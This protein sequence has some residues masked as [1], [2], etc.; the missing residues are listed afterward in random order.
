[1]SEPAPVTSEPSQLAL[2]NTL[3]RDL[4]DVY[5]AHGVCAAAANSLASH[6]QVRTLTA[7][8]E[9]TSSHYDVWICSSEGQISQDRW[10]D[11]DPFLERIAEGDRAAHYEKYLA[12]AGEHVK[13]QLWR[14]IDNA[15]LAV[16]IP[17]PSRTDLQ[18]PS[19][20]ICLLDPGP[21]CP[22]TS[23]GLDSTSDVVGLFLE[24]AFLRQKT[25]Q[26]SVEFGI[27]SDI[28]HSLTS[29]LN[30]EEIIAQVTYAVRRVLGAESLTIGLTDSTG[31]KVVFVEALMGPG[32]RDVPSVSFKIGQGIAGWVALHGEPAIVN[33]AYADRRFSSR[34]DRDTGFLTNS[35]LCVPLKVEQRVIGVLEAINKQNGEFDEND[36][37][38]LQAISGP[39]AVA[40]E[41]ALL[42]SDVLAEKRRI[43][44]IFARM[45]EGLLTARV[46]GRV[47]AAN[48]ALLELLGLDI[49]KAVGQQAGD[50]VVT[51]PTEFGEFLRSV[52]SADGEAPQLAGDLR[53]ADGQ[54]VPVLVSGSKIDRG[55]GET[56]EL[57]FVFSDL[58]QVR[59]V[60]RMRDDFFH[61]IVH[62]LRTPLAT[63][64]M[65]ARL[66]RDGRIS[67]DELKSH[68]FLGII[69]RESDRLQK[70]VRQM[71]LLAKLEANHDVVKEESCYLNDV[72]EQLLPPL[73]DRA[74]VK[75]LEFRQDIQP[76]L[77]TVQGGEELL[78]MVF[79][80]L[81]ENGINF[82]SDGSVTIRARSAGDVVRVEVTDE[83]IGIPAEA[84]PNLFQRFY[85]AQSAVERGIAGTGLGLYM[86]KEGLE[87]CGG[88]ID[89]ESKENQGSKFIVKVPIVVS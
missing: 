45:S 58:R 52:R 17:A 54:F 79:K 14:L 20:T 87:T 46:D 62:E 39:L 16:Q 34:V 22:L 30:L 57:I 12:P 10:S 67:G 42:H 73:S 74:M 5:D 77:P 48:N 19:A 41:N 83:G 23:E 55:S 36:S 35:V 11:E 88:T 71:L 59:E 78:Y 81:V 51:R 61:N 86:V 64:L 44:T 13:S 31:D 89:V 26:Q 15:T 43:E 38:L 65:Y 1:M 47:S 33:D 9:R 50:I 75:G 53:Q 84:L 76:D 80:N 66:L 3:T 68:R 2:W 63:I 70:M 24:R 37:R 40:I 28:S 49:D 56:D 82:T 25:D 32:L 8:K 29:T 21:E 69:E 27:V 85:R 60:E 18:S 7:I 4:G 72:F 6:C